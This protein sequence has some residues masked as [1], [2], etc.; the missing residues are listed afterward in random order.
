MGIEELP[1]KQTK[2][3]GEKNPR[4]ERKKN[5]KK[6]KRPAVEWGDLALWL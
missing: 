4:T 2:N 3:T 1:A 6:L 5:R